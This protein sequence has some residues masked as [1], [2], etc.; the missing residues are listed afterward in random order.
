MSRGQA[1]HRTGSLLIYY[2]GDSRGSI[3]EAVRLLDRSFYESIDGNELIPQTEESP[4]GS[5][6]SM[7]SGVAMRALLPRAIRAVFT[8]FRALPLLGATSGGTD[9]STSPYS[10]PPPW[11]Y[12]C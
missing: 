5:L 11:E 12:L 9:A 10:T 6:A 3:L 8:V 7:L 2:E 4:G 1:S